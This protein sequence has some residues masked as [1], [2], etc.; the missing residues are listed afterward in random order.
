MVYDVVDRNVV[1][2]VLAGW[3]G[4]PVGSMVSD[5]IRAVLDR[6]GRRLRSASRASPMR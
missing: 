6:Q 5:E 1:A 2:E 4:I 3:T